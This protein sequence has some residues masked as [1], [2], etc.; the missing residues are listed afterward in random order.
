M[1]Q[2]TLYGYHSQTILQI[3]HHYDCFSVKVVFSLPID[4]IIHH[5]V[6]FGI[7]IIIVGLIIQSVKITLETNVWGCCVI[8]CFFGFLAALFIVQLACSAASFGFAQL[9]ILLKIFFAVC[10]VLAVLPL[11]LAI[12]LSAC[13]LECVVFAK[14]LLGCWILPR[15]CFCLSLTFVLFWTFQLMPCLDSLCNLVN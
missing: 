5:I 13:V 3:R 1:C 10:V 6:S 11:V 14:D 4:H 8:V 15:T 7:D 2:L 9:D 12:M